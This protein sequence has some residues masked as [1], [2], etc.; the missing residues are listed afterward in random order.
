MEIVGDLSSKLSLFR[1]ITCHGNAK[2]IQSDNGTNFIGTEKELKAAINK[3]DKEK[4]MTEIIKKV[5]HFLWGFNPPGGSWMGGAWESLNALTLDRIFTEE[6]PYTFLSEVESLLNNCPV[7]PSSED[8]NDYEALPPSHLILG[9]S[10]SNH[11]PCKCQMMKF[12]TRKNGMQCK[13]QLI[14]LGIDGIRNTYQHLFNN[15][16]GTKTQK[17]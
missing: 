5:I 2:N 8:I 6:A 10:S 13:Q 12:T 1:F 15:R 4:V 9:N 7:T 11:S 14:C 3:I 16:N 17:I